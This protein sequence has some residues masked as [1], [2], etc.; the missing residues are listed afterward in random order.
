M[1]TSF[2]NAALITL[3]AAIAAP[4]AA[5]CAADTETGEPAQVENIATSEQALTGFTSTEIVEKMATGMISAL[6]GQAI[7]ALF[8]SKGID[9]EKLVA[10]IDA[11]TRKALMDEALRQYQGNVN[12][13]LEKMSD[14]E[15]SKKVW[16]SGKRPSQSPAE[17]YALMVNNSTLEAVNQVRAALGP[18][19]PNKD[20]RRAG[21]NAYVAA[22]Q[23]DANRLVLQILL[24]NNENDKSNLRNHLRVAAAHV[25][26]TVQEMRQAEFD[27]RLGRVT[28]CY[29]YYFNPNTGDH[30]VQYRD[31]ESG[32]R[33]GQNASYDYATAMGRCDQ[34][35]DGHYGRVEAAVASNLDPQ[36]AFALASA[37]GWLKAADLIDGIAPQAS[38]RFDGLDFGGMYGMAGD[39]GG[40][41]VVWNVNPATGGASCPAGYD[42][43][44]F[45]G[46]MN[47]DWEAFQCVRKSN[48]ATTPALDFG[49]MYGQLDYREGMPKANNPFTGGQSCPAGFTSHQ[50]LGDNG[51]TDRD[52]FYCSRP[53]Q[54]GE[55]R[56]F[57][58]VYNR[59]GGYVNPLTG[60]ASCA[61][62]D[63]PTQV[64]GSGGTNGWRR[65]QRVVMCSPK[66]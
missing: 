1:K 8:P 48:G 40:K 14:F 65:D 29:E 6:G 57:G 47:V 28:S 54:A 23:I 11:N 27:R 61:Q 62:G 42:A 37:Q 41:G 31:E 12:A 44:R 55:T 43:V 60:G 13:A 63:K 58:G 52:L 19:A 10:N 49:G 3:L 34:D 2:K 24:A 39:Q 36:F 9:V 53:H 59:D 4:F 21:L 5:G 38:S 15:N 64:W 51:S 17:I 50:V 33:W 25:Q 45:A 16:D 30:N 56:K 46:K 66:G 20:F 18:D 35:R 26:G 7:D 22:E 32:A